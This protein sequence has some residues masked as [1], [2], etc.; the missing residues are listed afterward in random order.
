MHRFRDQRDEEHR[1]DAEERRRNREEIR[2]Q[3][4]E[5]TDSLIGD[6]SG[7]HGD[8]WRKDGPEVAEGER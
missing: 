4:S 3:G 5:A 7:E 1:D 6:V 8:N 2:F